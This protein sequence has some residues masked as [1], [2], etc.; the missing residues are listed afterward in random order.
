[1]NTF[2]RRVSLKV[3]KNNCRL[4]CADAFVR[5]GSYANTNYGSSSVLEVKVDNNT[6]YLRKS[7]L[8][9][10][11]SSIGGSSVQSAKLRVYVSATDGDASTIKLYANAIENWTENSFTWNISP[12]A[13]TY[14]GVYEVDVI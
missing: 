10:S 5:G 9:F 14:I 11:F 7:Y 2:H 12:A 3:R 13:V 6:S 8:K 1:M 4:W